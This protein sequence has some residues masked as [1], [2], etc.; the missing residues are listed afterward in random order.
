MAPGVL[1][2]VTAERRLE[3]QLVRYKNG[4]MTQ[5]LCTPREIREVGVEVVAKVWVL[6]LML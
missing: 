4:R 1:I 3:G 2:V 5:V 6:V